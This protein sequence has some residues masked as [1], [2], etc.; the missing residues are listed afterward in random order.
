MV[1]QAAAGQHTVGD[2]LPR[3]KVG[4]ASEL[5]LRNYLGRLRPR[6]ATSFVAGPIVS[7]Q[8][9]IEWIPRWHSNLLKD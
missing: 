7:F 6:S 3:P 5:Q 4:D 2:T 1:L 8:A 9:R